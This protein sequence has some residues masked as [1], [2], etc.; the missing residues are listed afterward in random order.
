MDDTTAMN[1]GIRSCG[2]DIVA[3]DC[4]DTRTAQALAD[5]LRE[6]GEWLECVAGIASC[7]AQFDLA[8][9]SAEEATRRMSSALRDAPVAGEAE[10]ELVEVPVC[11]GGEHGPDLDD[12]CKLLGVTREEFIEL[13]TGKDYRVEMLGFTPGFA[14]IGGFDQARDVPRR[15]EPRV[16]LAASPGG[17]QIVGRTPMRLFDT[18][19]EQPFRLRAGML[20]RFVAI[21]TAEFDAGRME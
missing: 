10:T 8:A 9:I 1:P 4:E 17:W 15:S 3:V 12:V 16:R 18:G 5:H 14:F 19:A 21:N 2:D 6:S 13:H 11:Y 20:V 7:V